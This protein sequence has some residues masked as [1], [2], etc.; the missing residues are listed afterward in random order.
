[1]GLLLAAILVALLAGMIFLAALGYM[2]LAEVSFA[3]RAIVGTTGV[4]ISVALAS[5]ASMI[6]SNLRSDGIAHARAKAAAADI[7][8][9]QDEYPDEVTSAKDLVGKGTGGSFVYVLIPG[10]VA[11]VAVEA[12]DPQ[13][14]VRRSYVRI[15]DRVKECKPAHCLEQAQSMAIRYLTA[16][17]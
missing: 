2:L 16:S 1:M 7:S 13:Y 8:R 17:P 10:K 14:L 9:G 6:G 4:L 5:G 15:G 12:K 3:R 11:V